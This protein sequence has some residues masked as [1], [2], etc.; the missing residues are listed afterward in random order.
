[1]FLCNILVVMFCSIIFNMFSSSSILCHYLSGYSNFILT[2]YYI[3][4]LYLPIFLF[5][6]SIQHLYGFTLHQLFLL[7]LLKFWKIV[8]LDYD[9]PSFEFF[10]L[11]LAFSSIPLLNEETLD[12]LKN[13]LPIGSSKILGNQMKH[14]L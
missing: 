5:L 4:Y 1:M 6:I 13:Q 11:L 8:A 9:I 2:V 3:V 12:C 14:I 7:H 10:Y